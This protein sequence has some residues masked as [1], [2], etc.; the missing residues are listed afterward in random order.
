MHPLWRLT[1]LLIPMGVSVLLL[2]VLITLGYRNRRNPL[3]IPFMFFMVELLILMTMSIL[4]LITVD[5][6]L[7]LLFSDL[8]FLGTTFLPATWLSIVLIYTDKRR[9][10]AHLL[11]ALLVVP[12]LTNFII[13]SNDYH[14]LWRGDSYRDVTTTWFPM[15]IYDYGSWYQSVYLPAAY[16][17]TFFA[18]FLLV[19]AY[20][21]KERI[22]RTQIMMMLVS[23]YLPVSIDILYRMGFELIPHFNA[24]IF[25]FPISG[26]LLG[27]ALLRFQLLKL[28]PIARARVVEYME[29]LMVVLDQQHHVVDVNTAAIKRLAAHRRDLIG[30]HVHDLFPDQADFVQRVVHTDNL[31]D[32]ISVGYAGEVRHFA[33]QVSPIRYPSG[34][35]AGKLLL[36]NDITER[37]EAEQVLRV[38]AREL[39]IL[40]ERGRIARD[41]HDSVNQTLFAAS[42]LADLL[43]KAIDKKPE[44]LHEYALNIR[45]LT[46]GATAQ[47]RLILL[48]LYPDALAQTELNTILRHLCVAFT[49]D[50]G[51]VVDF[52]GGHQIQVERSVQLAFYRIAQEALH[53]ICKHANASKVSVR[54]TQQNACVELV[55]EDNGVGFGV[56]STPNGH[57][58]LRNMQQ[59]A[60]EVDATLEIVSQIS[61][62][63]KIRVMKETA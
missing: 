17:V 38:Q 56:H 8:S 9:L 60:E 43:P 54:L 15:M 4:E 30:R 53:N 40:E 35:S 37:R 25:V 22:Y 44:K 33:L 7:S 21:Q 24:S 36:L 16:V 45:Q 39:A 27:W 18:T 10:L 34:S 51:M 12:V 13:W 28:T 26:V 57:F 48:E 62:G 63:T 11:P 29:D 31:Q 42:A 23:L 52:E 2:I 19:R 3:A 55:I 6:E 58:G 49:G 50:T 14:H 46:Q 47:M 20:F 5:F 41:L 32:E 61:Q 59:R 1:P